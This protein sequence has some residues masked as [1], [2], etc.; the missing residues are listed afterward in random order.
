MKNYKIWLI[1]IFFLAAFLR[2][3]KLGSL[4]HTFHED[5]VLSGYV[6]RYIIQNGFDLYGNKWPFWYFN[7][8]GDY[9]IIGPIY[10]SGLST[11]IFGINEFA[12]RFPAAF[13]G[14]LTIF[15]LF[16]FVLEI[17]QNKRIALFSALF[18]A[19]LPWHLV[20]SRSTTEGV[21]GSFFF[22]SGLCFLLKSLKNSFYRNFFFSF[23]LFLVGYWIYHP[24]R[25]YPFLTL[26]GFLII[27]FSRLK[28]NKNH[29]FLLII[30]LLFFFFFSFYISQTSWG[31][32]RFE[33][34]SIFSVLSG[35]FIRYNELFAQDGGQNVLITR[36][37]H[38][39]VIGY[40]REFLNQY[41]GYLSP[42]YLFIDGWKKSRYFVPEIGLLY[43][44]FGLLILI[45]LIEIKGFIDKKNQKNLIFFLYLLFI[46][47]FPVSLTVVES[48]NPH[49]SLFF[50]ILL[51]IFPALGMEKLEKLRLKLINFRFL[52]LL[53][54][55]FEFI[56][57]IHNFVR[58]FDHF[59]SLNRND[60]QKEVARYV[61]KKENFYQQIYLPAQAAMSWYYLFYK[62]DFNPLY[63]KK[64]KLD[65]R[66]E[67]TGN[68][69]YIGNACPSTLLASQSIPKKSLIIDRY[70]CQSDKKFREIDKIKGVN[71]LLEYKVLSN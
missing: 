16:Y 15:P 25:V 64:F 48:P 23:F 18:L 49:R 38:N 42:N 9:Y 26:I 5:E 29:L 6:G 24:F 59:S 46:S 68:V 2:L 22:L 21:I 63:S 35:V 65:S 58:H 8:F 67:N 60:P 28:K 7:K 19:I 17:F 51:M 14:A 11:Y 3:Y 12:V 36:F 69:F 62:K 55:F 4:P 33:Q 39:K 10:L 32:G 52:I 43:F 54:L 50:G 20:L 66:I 40:G 37:F 45:S 70:D 53:V 57:F 61:I 31:K 44:V 34:T 13:F 1:L 71:L 56:L 27:Y 30:T 41:F 47:L